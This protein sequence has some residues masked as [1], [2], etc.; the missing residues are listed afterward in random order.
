MKNIER[1]LRLAEAIKFFERVC[2]ITETDDNGTAF[3]YNNISDDSECHICVSLRKRYKNGEE[4]HNIHM[5]LV[6]KGEKTYTEPVN[7]F[8]NAQI[9]TSETI[10]IGASDRV[11]MNRFNKLV[12]LSN[13]E[14]K[15]FSSKM[16]GDNAIYFAGKNIL[17][18]NE[19]YIKEVLKDA[20][21]GKGKK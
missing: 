2:E 1:E 15:E 13:N 9:I 10:K 21:K 12:E 3:A 11:V 14:M 19:E 4:F 18:E 8:S 20:G 6:Y 5:T 16:F 7:S 17:R